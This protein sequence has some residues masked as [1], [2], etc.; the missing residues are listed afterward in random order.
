M[1][2]R[3]RRSA[4]FTLIETI[5]V[6]VILG[7]ALSI[8]VGFVPR[9]NTTLELGAATSRVSDALRLARA[10]AMAEGHAVAFVAAPGGHGFV[11]D[12]VAV[13]LD[14]ATTVVMAQPRI[15]FSADGS[16][17]GGVLRVL[18]DGRERAISVDWLTGRVVVAF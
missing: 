3:A 10:R 15:V 8:V 16:S 14:R 7:L 12:N 6:L 2:G 17:S 5:V 1:A 11:V 13:G 9:R 4:G 18:V